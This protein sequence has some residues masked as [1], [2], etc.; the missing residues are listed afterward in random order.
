MLNFIINSIKARNMLCKGYTRY[1]A[2]IVNEIN[3]VVLSVTGTPMVQEF[4]NVF[5]NILPRLAL[6]QE[7][8]SV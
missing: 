2:H 7:V 3:E 4:S 1:L 8:E 5:P 6:E